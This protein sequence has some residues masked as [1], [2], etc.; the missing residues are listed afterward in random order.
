MSKGLWWVRFVLFSLIKIKNIRACNGV[1]VTVIL[2]LSWPSPHKQKYP[3]SLEEACSQLFVDS[4]MVAPFACY[5]C[6]WD[7]TIHAG[8]LSSFTQSPEFHQCPH[9]WLVPTCWWSHRYTI[10]MLHYGFSLEERVG[11]GVSRIGSSMY[12]TL[13]SGLY[14]VWWPEH[15][16]VITGEPHWLL[17]K[18]WIDFKIALMTYIFSAQFGAPVYLSIWAESQLESI[19]CLLYWPF[20]NIGLSHMEH[21][22]SVAVSHLE[23]I[24]GWPPKH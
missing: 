16:T 19:W 8:V 13:L 1:L 4:E 9:S 10:V 14:P 22:L 7:H 12:K 6:D 18:C 24:P 3:P 5:E 2:P 15:I 17:V 23:F 11:V 21:V 20:E